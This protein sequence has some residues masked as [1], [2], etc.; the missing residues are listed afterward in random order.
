MV[1]TQCEKAIGF[2][3]LVLSLVWIPW[4]LEREVGWGGKGRSILSWIVSGEDW[5][6]LKDDRGL[7][8]NDTTL[9]LF[10]TRKDDEGS[11][12]RVDQFDWDGE[13]ELN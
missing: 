3:A 4:V 1:L 8:T 9:S 10:E 13:K 11:K 2:K 5:G 6:P 12:R 7:S